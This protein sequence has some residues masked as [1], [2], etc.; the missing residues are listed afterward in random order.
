MP[1]RAED[2]EREFEA[3]A[4]PCSGG[5]L[6]LEAEDAIAL[7]RRAEAA[8]IPILGV[9][10]FMIGSDAAGS[11]LEH[12]ADFSRMVERGNGCRDDATAFIEERRDRL[13]FEVVL[14]DPLPSSA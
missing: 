10:G 13:T 2:L 8:R 1:M 12:I 14:G 9:D 4:V 3:R 7:V 5:L 6:I 11:P